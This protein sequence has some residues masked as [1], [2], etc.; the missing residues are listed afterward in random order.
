MENIKELYILG[1]PIDT[2]IGKLH[3][4]KVKEYDE[5]L[6]Y[7]NILSL[8]K[9][10][11]LQVFKTASNED[12][13]YNSLVECL[14]ANTLFDFICLFSQEELKETWLGEFYIQFKELFKFCF[15]EDV[16]NLIENNE[17]FEKY[18]EL[19]KKI[20]CVNIE[21]PNPNPE[22]ERRNQ[23]RKLLEKNKND[24]IT[25]EAMFTSIEVITGR[26]PNEMTLY[27]FYK[28]F[29][30]ICQVKNYDTST[31]FATVSAEAKIEA[32]YKDLDTKKEELYITEE[33]LNK[34]RKNKKLQQNL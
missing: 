23:L 13:N 27:Q 2:K 22:I 29:E 32:W 28:T 25:F 6:K 33:Q 5:F 3:F 21:K 30:R 15:K 10:D 31:L 34:A 17:E 14:K 18:R 19:I 16:F 4:V 12:S 26:D 24:N 1:K 9:Q 11:L 20:N 7:Y 8:E